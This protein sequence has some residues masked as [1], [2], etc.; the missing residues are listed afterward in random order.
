MRGSSA[1]AIDSESVRD[2]PQITPVSRTPKS[3]ITGKRR[4]NSDDILR[5]LALMAI[6]AGPSRTNK[7][8]R[9]ACDCRMCTQARRCQS[10]RVNR[11]ARVPILR[12]MFYIVHTE[13]LCGGRD[14]RRINKS[15]LTRQTLNTAGRHWSSDSDTSPENRRPETGRLH[16]LKSPRCYSTGG[17]IPYPG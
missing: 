6:M 15:D 2:T 8:L 9:T 12:Y 13:V 17:D 16:R 7:R 14:V 1:C 11:R 4:W 10:I 5:I 3:P